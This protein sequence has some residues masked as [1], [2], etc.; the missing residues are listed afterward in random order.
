GDWLQS[1]YS[2]P[3][4]GDGY[5]Q[6]RNSNKG[7]SRVFFPAPT[8]PGQYEVRMCYSA[9]GNRASN[10]PVEIHLGDGKIQ[11]LVVNQRKPP[12]IDGLWHSLGSYPFAGTEKAQVVIR[13]DGTDGYVFAD[14]VLYIK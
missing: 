2:K 14:A 1:T 10:V 4:F 8:E 5:L 7:K 9:S 6:D 11:R 13:N 12:E 3:F